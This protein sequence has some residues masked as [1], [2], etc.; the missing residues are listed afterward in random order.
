VAVLINNSTIDGVSPDVYN[1][2]SLWFKVAFSSQPQL[3]VTYLTSYAQIGTVELAL[4]HST[5]DS[6]SSSTTDNSSSRNTTAIAVYLLDGRIKDRYSIPRTTI[7]LQSE[8][9]KTRGKHVHPLPSEVQQGEYLVALRP[10]NG[11]KLHGVK[12]KLLGLSS[13]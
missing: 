9:G 4:Y 2:Q 6:S 1:R 5:E 11:T 8:P 7:L 3:Q 12:F 13:C 10:V